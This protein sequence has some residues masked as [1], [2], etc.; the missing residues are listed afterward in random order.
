MTDALRVGTRRSTLARAQT[1]TV[2]RLIED[3]T[4]IATAEVLVTSRGDVDRTRPLHEALRFGPGLFTAA[5]E[6]ALRAGDIDV[7]VHS[8]KDLP[9]AIPPE[10]PIVAVPAREDPADVLVVAV[11]HRDAAR[12][13]LGLRAGARVGTSSP[14]RQTQILAAD[15][16]AVPTDVR[17]NVETRLDLIRAG[18]VDAVLLAGAGIRRAGLATPEGCVAV[19]LPPEAWPA[20]PG[21]GALAIQMRADDPRRGAVAALD[22][23]DAR[24]GADAER[25]VL[26]ALGGGC[27]MP[28]G[29]TFTRHDGGWAVDATLAPADWRTAPALTLARARLEGYDASALAERVAA[30]LTQPHPPPQAA[31][32]RAL[33]GA[34]V[35]ITFDA[36][37][38][39]PYVAAVEAAGGEAAAWPFTE[40][41]RLPVSPP[42]VGVLDAWRRAQWVLVTSPRAARAAQVLATHARDG[43]PRYGAVGPASARALRAAGLPVHLVAP[44]GT[45]ASLAD[46]V[47]RWTEPEGPAIVPGAE[48]PLPDLTDA[49]LERG[50]EVVPWPVYRTRPIDPPPPPP[51]ALPVDALVVT[52]PSAAHALRLGDERPARRVIAFG[53][54]TAA[55]LSERGVAVD[56]VLDRRTP[57]GLL[58]VLARENPSP[59]A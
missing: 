51:F 17:G 38:A 50:W 35:L 6:D 47:D 41:E 2:R 58:E 43:A 20:C 33:Q 32:T 21:Q 26:G 12:G 19:R 48:E 18:V 29:A 36:E 57:S 55:A 49:L 34:R 28:L 37:R 52:S 39:A 54:T 5:L 27:G 3:A 23:A 31:P 42:P 13:V 30:L 15:P 14:R 45:G 25:V 11:E 40:H 4:G 10:L 9:L 7:A 56:A 46:A 44:R 16:D 59:K 22:D 53:P 24:A 1:G 8:L